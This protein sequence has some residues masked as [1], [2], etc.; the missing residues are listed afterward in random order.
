MLTFLPILK[1]FTIAL[2]LCY[3]SIPL[4]A[5]HVAGG[6]ITYECLGGNQYRVRFVFF[7]D[8]GGASLPGSATVNIYNAAL[9]LVQNPSLSLVNTTTTNGVAPTP[10]TVIPNGVCLEIG[11]YEG[12]VTLPPIPGGYTLS[13]DICCRNGGIINGPAGSAAYYATIPD[14]SLASC[15]NRAV[16]NAWPPVFICRGDTFSFDYSA[17]DADGDSCLYLCLEYRSSYRR[18]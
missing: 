7:R 9:T 6:E 10:C 3:C 4:F 16:F 1:R 15:N 13:Y 12:I 17:T 5:S 14:A 2:L 8:C 11:E 18:C